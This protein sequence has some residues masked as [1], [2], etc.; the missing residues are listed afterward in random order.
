MSTLVTPAFKRNG[1]YYTVPV[2]SGTARISIIIAELKKIGHRN[3]SIIIII[4]VLSQRDR[5]SGK[6]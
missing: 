6:E 4:S 2:I 1:N 5:D 3:I